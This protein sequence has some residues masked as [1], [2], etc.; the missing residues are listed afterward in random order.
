MDN[1]EVRR[2]LLFLFVMFVTKFAIFNVTTMV[3]QWQNVVFGLN[4]G[5]HPYRRVVQPKH[6]VRVNLKITPQPTTPW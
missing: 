5:L 3:H 1:G 2:L 4:V 6:G